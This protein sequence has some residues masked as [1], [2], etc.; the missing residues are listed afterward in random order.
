[1]TVYDAWTTSGERKSWTFHSLDTLARRLGGNGWHVQHDT[2][3]NPPNRT[4]EITRKDRHGEH[5]VILVRTSSEAVKAAHEDAA[6]AAYYADPQP[7]AEPPG[8]WSSQLPSEP[9]PPSRPA[10]PERIWA[11][12]YGTCVLLDEG[13]S[14]VTGAPEFTLSTDLGPEELCLR[15]DL[16]NARKLRLALIRFEQ[17]H[18]PTHRKA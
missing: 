3:F 6:R 2:A 4:I 12:N 14:A 13:E 8:T 5:V 7:Q 1:M 17:A 18:R 11:D 10:K 9:P 15:F 16:D